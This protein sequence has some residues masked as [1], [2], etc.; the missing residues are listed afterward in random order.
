M[1]LIRVILKVGMKWATI[2]EEEGVNV[3]LKYVCCVTWRLCHTN[4]HT[5]HGRH[6]PKKK[7]RRFRNGLVR[8]LKVNERK[9]L[10][11]SKTLYYAQI[12][13]CQTDDI[14]F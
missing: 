9:F 10:R 12:R 4:T 11:Q 2:E 5:V 8:E 1:F 13:S 3:L 6:T 14:S 7:M